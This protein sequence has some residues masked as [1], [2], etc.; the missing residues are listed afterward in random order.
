MLS[1]TAPSGRT[2]FRLAAVL[3]IVIALKIISSSLSDGIEFP[4]STDF[5][6][7][8]L[9]GT[10]LL[11]GESAYW[12]S[13]EVEDTRRLACP[14]EAI[15]REQTHLT[16]LHP[17]LNTPTFHLIFSLIAKLD[18]STA[19]TAWC[20]LSF[21]CIL[22]FSATIA[23]QLDRKIIAAVALISYYPTYCCLALGQ[24]TF[25][26]AIPTALTWKQ[27]RRDREVSAGLWLGLA[28]SLKPFLLVISFIL[29][30]TRKPRPALF[31]LLAAISIT[32]ISASQTGGI[33]GFLSDYATV[34]RNITWISASWNASFMGF[35]GR[36]LDSGGAIGSCSA[37]AAAVLLGA[38][39]LLSRTR[40]RTGHLISADETM[41]VAIPITLLLS[42]LGWLYYFPLL[43][44]SWVAW[45]RLP[46]SS[47]H[48]PTTYAAALLL[49]IT[50][51][52][53]TFTDA[54]SIEKGISWLWHPPIYTQALCFFL[55]TLISGIHANTKM[56][57]ARAIST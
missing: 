30:L 13:S 40:M 38:I 57:L 48:K 41:A 16:C 11:N 26:F 50:A 23:E 56:R 25:L 9:S 44:I 33:S 27:L 12:T 6:K 37:L 18:Y 53:Q 1:N 7:F 42:P 45:C 20:A 19:W 47:P 15:I 8:H 28:I 51:I 31:S 17:D 39:E 32:L 10:R 3:Y 35:F 36:I 46:A 2:A 49:L 29:F 54:P 4:K 52:P 21:A 55:V 5:Y 14:A 34:A 43:A 22:T 24:N